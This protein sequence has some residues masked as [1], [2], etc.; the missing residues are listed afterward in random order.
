MILPKISDICRSRKIKLF[1]DAVSSFGAEELEFEG[2]GITACAATANK[3]IHGAPGVSFAIMRRDAL[4]G[5]NSSARTF[6]LD[7]TRHCMQQ[8][9][10]GTAFTQPVHLF[11]A[12]AQALT[13]LKDQGGWPGR[14]KHYHNLS[15]R[16]RTGLAELGV[17]PMLN[18]YETSVVLGAYTLPDGI[19]YEKLHAALKNH[20]FIIYAGQGGFNNRIFRVSTMGDITIDTIETFLTSCRQVFHH[21]LKPNPNLSS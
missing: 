12:L 5:S 2:W 4:P 15:T 11:Y 6:Y 19:S 17:N 9:N 20:G 16:V 3:C 21:E 13:E 10:Q 1:V 8:D 7:L 14:Q 18:Q